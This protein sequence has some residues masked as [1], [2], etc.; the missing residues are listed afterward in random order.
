MH[1][2]ALRWNSGRCDFLRCDSHNEECSVGVMHQV[3]ARSGQLAK[4]S[5]NTAV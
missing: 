5:A 4:A 3:T 1:H 2:A